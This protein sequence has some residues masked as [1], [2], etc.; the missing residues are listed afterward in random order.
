MNTLSGTCSRYKKKLQSAVE[1]MYSR[2]DGTNTVDL[3]F[4]VKGLGF[5]GSYV[6]LIN[7]CITQL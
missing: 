6:R 4:R 7:L 2:I 1:H 5:S 3:G